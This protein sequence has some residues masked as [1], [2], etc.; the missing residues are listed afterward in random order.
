VPLV[1]RG[2]LSASWSRSL[3][4]RLRPATRY[5]LS[6]CAAD[7][8]YESAFDLSDMSDAMDDQTAGLMVPRCVADLKPGVC[9]APLHG[10]GA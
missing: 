8:V 3:R 10:F 1:H 5:G 2:N 4:H 9:D 6:G 7:D